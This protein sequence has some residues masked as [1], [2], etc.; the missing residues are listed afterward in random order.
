LAIYTL[1]RDD[2][3]PA[4]APYLLAIGVVH[5]F[6]LVEVVFWLLQL[7]NGETSFAHRMPYHGNIRHFGYLGYLA[8]AATAALTVLWPR[9]VLSSTLLC[10]AA[11]FGIV[12]LGSRG[13]LLGWSVFLLCGWALV[14]GRRRLL[15]WSLAA[16]VIAFGLSWVAAQQGW[17]GSGSLIDRAQQGELSGGTGRLSLWADV[18]RAIWQHPWWG[19]GPDG[20]RFLDCGQPCGPYI[21]RT[22]QPH[23]LLLQLLEEFGLIGTVLIGA[24]ALSLARAQAAPRGW[25]ALAR[26]QEVVALLLA[27]LAGLLAF[28]L[29][30]G[31]FYYPVPLLISATL[32]SLLLAAARRASRSGNPHQTNE[33]VGHRS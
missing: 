8:A 32:S 17:L 29:V 1:H 15:A 14:P 20:H 3:R 25:W 11:L 13:A 22:S 31:P 33:P 6:V 7:R 16:T 12:Q 18:L 10:A 4:A 24:L 2:E 28:G 9:L 19:Y 26:E 23:N 21:A 5:A 27:M 30:D